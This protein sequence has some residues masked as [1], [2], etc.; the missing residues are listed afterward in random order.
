VT[1][2]KRPSERAGREGYGLIW[3]KREAEYFLKKDWTTQITL[4]VLAFL[5]SSRSSLKPCATGRAIISSAD[6]AHDRQWA[7]G[8]G[9]SYG[10]LS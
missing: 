3:L 4:M 9:D 8:A 10:Q 1:I 7:S 2:A 6:L 5:P